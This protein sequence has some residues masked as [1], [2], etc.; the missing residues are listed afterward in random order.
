MNMQSRTAEVRGLWGRPGG[1]GANISAYNDVT[2]ILDH[3]T[4]DWLWLLIQPVFIF[5]AESG[6]EG[7]GHTMSERSDASHICFLLVG[8]T[9][10][11][12]HGPRSS[13]FKEAW[14][15]F[16]E[17]GDTPCGQHGT[18]ERHICT[19][20]LGCLHRACQNWIC[21]KAALMLNETITRPK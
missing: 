2:S 4:I 5:S 6:W 15:S 14:F 17:N 3:R 8:H 19:T 20:R 16:L 21:I 9:G 13:D 10:D 12:K 11:C 7:V 1:T 18:H